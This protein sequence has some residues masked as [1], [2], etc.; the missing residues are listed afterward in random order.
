[1]K[2]ILLFFFVVILAIGCSGFFLYK[3]RHHSLV[4]RLTNNPVFYKEINQLA[5]ISDLLFLPLE[6]YSSTLPSYQLLIDPLDLITLEESLPQSNQ[7]KLVAGFDQKASATFIDDQNQSYSVKLSYRGNNALHWAHPKKSY[8]IEFDSP[9]TFK[10]LHTIDLIIP[11]DRGLALEHLANY[12]AKKL[13]LLAPDSWFANLSLNHQPVSFYY[14]TEKIDQHFLAKRNLSGV[15]FKEKDSV[16]SWNQSIYQ[17]VNNW[18]VDPDNQLATNNLKQLIAIL[19]NQD[20]NSE[21]L[22]LLIDLDNFLA[23]QVHSVLMASIHQDQSHNNNLVF[24][25]KINKFQFIPWD[26]GQRDMISQK[27]NKPYHPV[28]DFLLTDPDIVKK[29]DELLN[30]YLAKQINYQSDV[31]IFNQTINQIKIPLIQDKQKF[32]PNIKY[33]LDIKHHQNWLTNYQDIL[34]AQLIQNEKN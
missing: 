32:H 34:K 23:W 5:K 7:V 11:E 30:N 17:D 12:R 20:S 15:L 14:V 26:T 4:T 31:D 9:D 13:N 16:S 21:D 1:M 6:F 10:N 28:V 25:E 18:Q 19:N 3:Y 29:R 8:R 22:T 27:L 2:R 24:N 33:I